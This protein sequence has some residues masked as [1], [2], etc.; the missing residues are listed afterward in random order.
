M[1]RLLFHTFIGRQEAFVVYIHCVLTLENYET[2]SNFV[3]I[4][5]FIQFSTTNNLDQQNV[6]GVICIHHQ[7]FCIKTRSCNESYRLNKI[8]YHSDKFQSRLQLMYQ[9]DLSLKQ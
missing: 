5:E 1:G 9:Y 7:D 8:N 6:T 2:F 3:C 4:Y